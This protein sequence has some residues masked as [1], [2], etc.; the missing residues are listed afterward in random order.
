[1][2]DLA[3]RTEARTFGPEDLPQGETR[4]V[5]LQYD[6]HP[7]VQ[8]REGVVLDPN[9]EKKGLSIQTF[10]AFKMEMTRRWTI[11]NGEEEGAEDVSYVRVIPYK[12]LRN[13]EE[14]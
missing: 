3:T 8:V 2:A 11:R 14:I 1:M 7:E 13:V 10:P 4:R 5:Y 6:T 12:N 9:C